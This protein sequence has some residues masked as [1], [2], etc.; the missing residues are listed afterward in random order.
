MI[1]KDKPKEGLFDY[2]IEAY[3]NVKKDIEQNGKAAISMATG[4]GKSFVAL[5]LLADNPDK[6]ILFVCPTNVIRNQMYEY[7]AKYILNK[8]VSNMDAKQ[9]KK[10]VNEEYPNFKIATYAGMGAINQKLGIAPKRK[11]FEKDEQNTEDINLDQDYIIMDELHRD[12]AENWGAEL[13]KFILNNPNAKLL[14]MTATPQRMDGIDLIDEMFDGKLSYNLGLEEASKK[15]I[16]DLPKYYGNAS[17]LIEQLKDILGKPNYL[18]KLSDNEKEILNSKLRKQFP[19]SDRMDIPE[20]LSK[21]ITKKDGRYI[22][23]CKDIEHL[24]QTQ[25]QLG[26]WFKYIDKEP[27]I[28]AIHTAEKGEK[29]RDKKNEKE[30]KNFQHSKSEHIKILLSVDMCNEGLHIDDV[31][32][33]ILNAPTQSHIV[34]S[35]Q[36]GRVVSA[37]SQQE[38]KVIIDLANNWLYHIIKNGLPFD[39]EFGNDKEVDIMDKQTGIGQIIEIMKKIDVSK[40]TIKEE[41]NLETRILD[42]TKQKL[43]CGAMFILKAQGINNPEKIEELLTN[44]NETLPAKAIKDI[45]GTYSYMSDVYAIR[46]DLEKCIQSKSLTPELLKNAEMLLKRMKEQELKA[47][48][49][50]KSPKPE[51]VDEAVKEQLDY[52]TLEYLRKKRDIAQSLY[53]RKELEWQN[54]KTLQTQQRGEV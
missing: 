19:V 46:K 3:E 8:D 15:E 4:C 33:V 13:E 24:R 11:K 49:P 45:K 41:L 48:K 17:G 47:N 10:V 42:C 16:I 50:K 52:T 34:Y 23:F 6:N 9:V 40:R 39:I 1:V 14:G 32:G 31:N 51:I 12:G 27:E 22:V 26:E 25:E 36:N 37:H 18:G 28:Y 54:L 38:R 44:A 29:N 2:Q 30:L 21:C 20:L 7:I 5:Q 43:Q 53:E 35:Q